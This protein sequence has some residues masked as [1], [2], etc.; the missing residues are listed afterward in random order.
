MPPGRVQAEGAEHED[1][2]RPAEAVVE[3]AGQGVGE[4]E[5]DG[6]GVEEEPGEEVGAAP[7]LEAAEGEEV[8]EGGQRGEHGD[9]QTCWENK[10]SKLTSSKPGFFCSLVPS[11]VTFSNI[12]RF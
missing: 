12:F 4:D 1:E 8:H 11:E 7:Q 3:D 6:E 9:H 5:G 10:D 2:V